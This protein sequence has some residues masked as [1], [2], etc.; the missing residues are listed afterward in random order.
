[1]LPMSVILE[2]LELSIST[3]SEVLHHIRNHAG[4]EECEYQLWNLIN[5]I[6]CV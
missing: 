4:L 2:R 1:M 6:K 3:C 5:S